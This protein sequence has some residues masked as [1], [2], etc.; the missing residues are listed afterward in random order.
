MPPSATVL[1]QQRQIE[2]VGPGIYIVAAGTPAYYPAMAMIELGKAGHVGERFLP[3]GRREVAVQVFGQGRLRRNPDG[4]EGETSHHHVTIGPEFFANA[5]KDYY[6]WP[7]KFWR[8]VV[9]NSVDAGATRIDLGVEERPD[10]S[11]LVFAD[12]NGSGM[13]KSTIIDKFLVL[14]ASSKTGV[15]GAAGGFGKAKE[16]VLFPWMTW[17]ISSQDTVVDGRGINFTARTVARRQGTR[18]EVV[19]PADKTTTPAHAIEFIKR[20]YLPQVRF[21]VNGEV[22]KANLKADDLIDVVDGKIEVYFTRDEKQKHDSLYVRTR[23]LFMFSSYLGELPGYAIAELIAPSVEL[24]TANRDGWRDYSVQRAVD[25]LTQRV[26]KDTMSAL[27][28]KQGLIREKISGTG[29]FTSAKLAAKMMQNLRPSSAKEIS[30]ADLSMLTDMLRGGLPAR[31]TTTTVTRRGGEDDDDGPAL[32]DRRSMAELDDA[33]GPQPGSALEQALEAIGGLPSPDSMLAALGGKFTGPEHIE[34]AIKQISWEPDF[35]LVN[36]IEGYKVPKK[37]H[38]ITMTPTVRK[39][40]KVWTELCRYV[41]IQ[42]GSSRQF[43]VGFVF[44]NDMLA[45]AIKEDDED[46]LMLNPFRT[47][48]RW[49]KHEAGDEIYRPTDENDLKK[50]YAFAIHEATHIA[51]GI[52]YHDESFS[53]AMTMNMAKC[54]D[55]WRKIRAIVAGIKMRGPVTADD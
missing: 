52:K 35:F 41:L 40:A 1:T 2:G 22:H 20:C 47:L 33:Y 21:T 39:L 6:D 10:G 38:P 9:Q 34:A 25:A 45:A 16:L 32:R 50:L 54:A 46:W 55:G 8:E 48:R 44:S 19:M 36:E 15:A 27:K 29:K 26:A 42:V 11:R 14:G 13:S 43:G 53:S 30:D 7:L 37:F 23:G 12:D 18:I 28:S 3:G 24:L 4:D 17:Q 49:G 51:D 5:I 31:G